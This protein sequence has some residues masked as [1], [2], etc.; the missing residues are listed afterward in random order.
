MEELKDKI[1]NPI[2]KQQPSWKNALSRASVRLLE[3]FDQKSFK[4]SLSGVTREVQ[5]QWG[6]N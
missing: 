5:K 3:I 4:I 6:G 2:E 1:E